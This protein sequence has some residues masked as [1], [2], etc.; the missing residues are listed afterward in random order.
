[1]V[2]AAVVVEVVVGLI[3]AVVVAVGVGADS[4]LVIVAS[5]VVAVLRS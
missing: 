2:V 1:M 3:V 5:P 4:F